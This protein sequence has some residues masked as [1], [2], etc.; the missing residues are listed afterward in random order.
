MARACCS[1]LPFQSFVHRQHILEMRQGAREEGLQPVEVEH[2]AV[3]YGRPAVPELK[4]DAWYVL[5]GEVTDEREAQ[6]LA[7]IINHQGPSIPA[8]VLAKQSNNPG[9]RVLAGPFGDAG[10]AHGVV[11]RLKVDLGIDGIVIEPVGKI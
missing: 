1:V 8:R 9:Y 11:K 10:K 7:A 3:L 5:A 4:L 6:R 2:P